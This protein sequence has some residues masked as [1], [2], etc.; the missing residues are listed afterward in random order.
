MQIHKLLRS[1][2]ITEFIKYVD[3]LS[4]EKYNIFEIVEAFVDS[5]LRYEVIYI[6]ILS[7]F[8]CLF[9]GENSSN[10]IIIIV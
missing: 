9:D 10:C 7:D 1:L 3:S 6:S 8:V 5:H 2:T 4:F